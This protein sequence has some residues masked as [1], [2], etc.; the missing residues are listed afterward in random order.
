MAKVRPFLERLSITGYKSIREATLEFD[1][2]NVLIGAN[3]A[4][5]SNLVSFFCFLSAALDEKETKLNDYVGRRG[6]P[7]AFLHFGGKRT[8]EIATAATVRTEVG[9]GT[10]YQRLGFRAPDSLLPLY[11]GDHPAF[12]RGID[13]SEVMIE[14]GRC[15]VVRD[16]R[17]GRPQLPIYFALKDAVA[18]CHL[19]D[20][21]LTAAIRTEGYIEDN[22]RLHS[23]GRN[24]AAMLYR[25]K[26]TNEN[27]YRRIQSA[28]RKIVPGFDDFVL[29]PRELNRQNILLNW[30]QL[31]QEYLFGPHQFAD[32]ALRAIALVALFL[33]PED[34]LPNLIV[35]DEPEL[36]L[37]PDAVTIIAGMARAASS[38]AQVLLATQSP[39]LLDHFHPEEVIVAETREQAA[40][41]RR[42][43]AAELGDWLPQYSLGELWQKNVLGGGPAP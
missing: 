10:L 17:Q 43:T 13:P 36:G 38:H 30:R 22:K 39:T 19:V 24:L 35:V 27:I 40:S 20:T 21:S 16:S 33:Q 18:T 5:K 26:K 31:G 37:H 14:H 34:E 11:Y 41:Y 15:A 42:V 28:I 9:T 2:L 4:G 25:Y 3:G 7:N 8:T 23:D 12:P 32:G 29:E 1:S 6:G